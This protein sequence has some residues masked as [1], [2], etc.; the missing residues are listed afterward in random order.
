MSQKLPP[1]DLIRR[2]FS[3]TPTTTNTMNSG[4]K[5]LKPKSEKTRLNIQTAAVLS[6]KFSHEILMI[7][8]F[9]KSRRAQKA[10]A[11]IAS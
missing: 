10:G 8:V 6:H 1:V 3:C 2:R 9:S 5:L 4:K 11:I 7:L